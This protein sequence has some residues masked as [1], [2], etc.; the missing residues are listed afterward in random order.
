M[1]TRIVYLF[2]LLSGILFLTGCGQTDEDIRMEDEIIGYWYALDSNGDFEVNIPEYSFSENDEGFTT[3]YGST[4]D[5][6]WEIKGGQLK[7]Y[8]DKAPDY[9]IGYDKYNSRSLFQIHK[10]EGDYLKVTQYYNDGFQSELEFYK[11]ID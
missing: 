2:I 6:H 3:L 1:K 8:Y 4:N 10:L 7:V 9:I 11:N 5:M